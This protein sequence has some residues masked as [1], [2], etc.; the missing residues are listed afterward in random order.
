MFIFRPTNNSMSGGMIPVP[1]RLHVISDIFNM[2]PDLRSLEATTLLRIPFIFFISDFVGN[3]MPLPSMTL[4]LRNDETN[5]LEDE[6]DMI[7]N[8]AMAAANMP[9]K[10]P[11]KKSPKVT[12]SKKAKLAPGVSIFP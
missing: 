6:M 1:G 7:R 5:S 4:T 11:A 10:T 12:I 2:V 8:Q 9:T 3:L